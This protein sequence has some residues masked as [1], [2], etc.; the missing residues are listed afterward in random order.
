MKRIKK[1]HAPKEFREWDSNNRGKDSHCY[2]AL[3]G[4]VK[5]VLMKALCEEQ[6]YLCAYTGL[7][8]EVDSA[9][10]EHI[11]PQNKCVNGE[12]VKYR[13]VIACFPV[14]GGD[15]SAGFGAPIKGGWWVEAS[16]VSPLA[17]DCE[18]RFRF[19]WS[20]KVSAFPDSNAPATKTIS[21]L[22]LGHD[23]LVELRR[24]AIR[25]FFGFG[26]ESEI[27]KDQAKEL[28]RK[29]DAKDSQGKFRPFDFVL[30]QLLT[31]YVSATKKGRP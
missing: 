27:T 31:K 22:E 30:K 23:S 12:D 13:N 26:T 11:K 8:I 3:P 16:F 9:H 7:S 2:D 17:S 25:G 5:R 28:L 1:T 14:D 4:T 21:V 6:G 10:I 19:K 15:K 24:M 18:N 20:G 29:I